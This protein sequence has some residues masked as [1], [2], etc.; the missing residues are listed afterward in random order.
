MLP[1]GAKTSGSSLWELAAPLAGWTSIQQMPM[2]L[3]ESRGSNNSGNSTEKL[4]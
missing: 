1:P 2:D 4:C 3:A